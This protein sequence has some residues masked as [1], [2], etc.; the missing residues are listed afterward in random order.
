MHLVVRSTGSTQTTK[1]QS[2]IPSGIFLASV[3]NRARLGGC[4]EIKDRLQMQLCNIAAGINAIDNEDTLLDINKH[5][6]SCISLISLAGHSKH[7]PQNKKIMPQRN[8]FSTKRKRQTVKV[9][10]AKPTIAEKVNVVNRLMLSSRK[11]NFANIGEF[12]KFS[13]YL[14]EHCICYKSLNRSNINAV[15]RN[16]R[17]ESPYLQC[18]S[19]RQWYS[20][21]T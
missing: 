11:A 3:Q 4:A 19:G 20:L 2:T 16:F 6:K 5:L 8:F 13:S 15:Q 9:R 1:E 10:M 18:F 7:E 21:S 14:D 12:C 17:R